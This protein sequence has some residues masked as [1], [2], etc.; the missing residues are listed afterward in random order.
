MLNIDYVL[1]MYRDNKILKEDV[2]V[3][4]QAKI[5]ETIRMRQGDKRVQVQR[6]VKE[7]VF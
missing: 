4:I 3:V 6:K 7:K 5:N 2:K 1:D